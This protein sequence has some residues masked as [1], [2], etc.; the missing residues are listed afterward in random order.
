MKVGGHADIQVDHVLWRQLSEIGE[1]T[2]Q[3]ATDVAGDILRQG[4]EAKVALLREEAEHE[5]MRLEAELTA[6]KAQLAALDSANGSSEA[7]QSPV[8]PSYGGTSPY[9]YSAVRKAV[10]GVLGS[11]RSRTWSMDEVLKALADLGY[12]T[13]GMYQQVNNALRK[14]VN[15]GEARRPV[16]GQYAWR[17]RPSQK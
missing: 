11:D 17:R 4:I 3:S 5:A 10:K 1:V 9:H 14:L 2:G 8:E 16:R 6:V 7:P 15:E 13:E 12:E